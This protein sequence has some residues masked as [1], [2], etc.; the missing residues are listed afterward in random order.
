MNSG[1]RLRVHQ[2]YHGSHHPEVNDLLEQENCLLETQTQHQLGA[3]TLQTQGKVLQRAGHALS[4]IQYMAQLLLQPGF[5]GPGI[6]GGNVSGTT[7]YST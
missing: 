6:Q 3:H 2:S 1:L 4:S 7:Y 5:I